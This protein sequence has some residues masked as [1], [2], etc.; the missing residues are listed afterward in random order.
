MWVIVVQHDENVTRVLGPY[1]EHRMALSAADQH[2]RD[3]R[4][5]AFNVHPLIAVALT[6]PDAKARLIRG[7]FEVIDGSPSDKEAS[8]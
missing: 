7:G 1:T 4:G 6:D 2:R 8:E 3:N 5:F